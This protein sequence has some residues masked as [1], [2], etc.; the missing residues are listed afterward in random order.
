MR[1]S[2]IRQQTNTLQI[3]VITFFIKPLPIYHQ[4]RVRRPRPRS[5]GI[6]RIQTIREFHHRDSN[7]L[8]S[9]LIGEYCCIVVNWTDTQIVFWKPH[10]WNCTH[11]QLKDFS[12]L[13]L[14]PSY[15]T[16]R[17]FLNYVGDIWAFGDSCEKPPWS[18]CGVGIRILFVLPLV[19]ALLCRR[20]TEPYINCTQCNWAS[21]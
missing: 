8:L 6:S 4:A 19:C 10:V 14:I 2:I 17:T 13:Q 16:R 1:Q 20:R 21:L 12:A 7:W 9:L 5:L 15:I 3:F 11:T 18:T